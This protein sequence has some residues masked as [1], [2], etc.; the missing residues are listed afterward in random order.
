M[1]NNI[2]LRFENWYKTLLNQYN[3]HP[4]VKDFMSPKGTKQEGLEL[5]RNICKS[6]LRSPQILGFLYAV[7]PPDS[8]DHIRDNLLE[9]LGLHDEMLSHPDLLRRLREAAGFTQAGWR[10][11]EE[12]SAQVLK[13]K[14]SEP[15]MFGTM[16]ELGLSVMIEVFGFEWF[17]S[18]ESSNIGKRLSKILNLN[19]YDLEWFFHHSEVDIE[20]AE[21]GLDTLVGYVNYFSVDD[22]TLIN[23][24][25]ITLRDNIFLKR[26]F[27][28]QVKTRL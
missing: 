27:D 3:N 12:E 24:V 21:Q 9:E 26:Y 20:H 4:V 13:N 15:I 14:I 2:R 16:T 25:E 6:H 5:V 17:L 8:A 18:R 10:A 7:T 11:V 1:A 19:D 28:L 22:E 23:I